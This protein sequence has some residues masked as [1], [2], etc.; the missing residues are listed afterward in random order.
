MA[1][2][3]GVPNNNNTR[4]AGHSSRYHPPVNTGAPTSASGLHG[5]QTTYTDF[6]PPR[7]TNIAPSLRAILGTDTGSSPAMQQWQ[8]Q[9]PFPTPGWDRGHTLQTPGLA[10]EPP[11]IPKLHINGAGP[12]S[13]RG[14]GQQP[15]VEPRSS[16]PGDMPVIDHQPRPR[17]SP[18]LRTLQEPVYQALGSGMVEPLPRKLKLWLLSINVVSSKPHQRQLSVKFKY[19]N[20]NHTTLPTTAVSADGHTWFASRPSPPPLPTTHPRTGAVRKFCSYKPTKTLT[21][22]LW[23]YFAR[24]LYPGNPR[25][26]RQG[27]SL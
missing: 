17:T 23:K 20:E 1:S 4:E 6:S 19:G 7:Q 11:T 18:P 21:W 10:L 5:D 16:T 15:L 22:S 14:F 12:S 3:S 2:R 24:I 9:G 26:L 25:F 13:L 27:L 8:G